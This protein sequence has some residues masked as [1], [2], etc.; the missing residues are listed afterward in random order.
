M[1]IFI[2]AVNVKTTMKHTYHTITWIIDYWI[3]EIDRYNKKSR[4]HS[5]DNRIKII[6]IR[7]CCVIDIYIYKK[8]F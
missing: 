3:I 2:I 7:T 5:P 6:I 1:D 8:N 4:I